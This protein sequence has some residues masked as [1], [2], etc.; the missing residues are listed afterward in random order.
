MVSIVLAGGGTAGHTSPLIAT[1]EALMRLQPEARITCIG[2]HKGL[3][4]HVIPQAGLDLR[5]V[6]PVPMPR[7]VNL[8][9]FRLPLRVATAVY[10]AQQ[11]LKEVRA[12]IVVGFGGYVSVPAYLAAYLSKIPVI[13]HEQNALPGIANKMA[14]RFAQVV[15]TTF[16]DTALPKAHLV[17]MPLRTSIT[18]LAH[19]VDEAKKIAA[20]KI[21]GLRHDMPTLLVSGGSQGARSINTAIYEAIPA[22]CAA[23]IQILH[24]WGSKNYPETIS[25]YVDEN[26][27]AIYRPW[28]YVDRMEEAYAVCDLMVARS[29]AGTVAETATIGLPTILVPLA[30]GNGEQAKNGAGA[31][32][33]GAAVMIDDADLNASS[34]SEHVCALMK[35]PQ[36]LK[37]MSDAGRQL[38]SSGAA[39]ELAE[40]TMRYATLGERR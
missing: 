6:D 39:D 17:G 9:L 11:I 13:V 34:L 4:T 8:D 35:D 1:A 5:L 25:E 27:G 18:D 26:T 19:G 30:V 3:E 38:F 12:D 16:A 31:V 32:K 15:A 33:A 20:E 37:S 22:I 40:I 2:T 23:G 10:Q 14:A 28:R 24:V 21:F 29:G 36:R 7:R